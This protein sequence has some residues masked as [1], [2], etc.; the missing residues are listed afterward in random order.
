MN[1]DIKR[2]CMLLAAAGFDRYGAEDVIQA[3]KSSDT[4]KILSELDR[5]NKVLMAGSETKEKVSNKKHQD[6]YYKDRSVAE[7]VYDLLITESRLSAKQG[8]AAFEG[9][10]REAYPNKMVVTPNPK[11][12]FTAWIRMLSRDFSDS[13]L[14]HVASRLRNQIVHGLNDKDDW[15]LKE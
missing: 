11:N 5:F 7:K 3:I 10:L 12:G 1:S 15:I 8:F 14:L 9:M 13:E 6:D 4:K 2:L